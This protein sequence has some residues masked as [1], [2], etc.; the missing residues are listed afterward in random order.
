MKLSEITKDCKVKIIK[1]G[2]CEGKQHQEFNGQIAD[3]TMVYDDYKLRLTDGNFCSNSKYEAA[4]TEIELIS[5]KIAVHVPIPELWDRVEK[6]SGK[7]W[8]NGEIVYNWWKKYKEQS[9]IDISKDALEFCDISYYQQ[10]DYTIIE[11]EDYLR[12]KY[13]MIASYDYGFNNIYDLQTINKPIKKGVI[14]NVIDS[15][16]K[17]ALKTTN[18]NEY[19]LREAGFHD[20][21]GNLTDAGRE[22]LFTY[23]EAIPEVNAK[24]VADANALIADKKKD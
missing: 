10:H 1:N 5:E 7:K 13:P 18:P 6:A 23:L 16:K 14:M 21:C 17:L 24:F 3:V 11:A 8:S 22:L 12:E 4:Q 2:C 9:C 15:V 20:E 19:A